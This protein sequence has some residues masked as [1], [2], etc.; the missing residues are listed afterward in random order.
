MRKRGVLSIPAK[1][2]GRHNLTGGDAVVL[3]ERVKGT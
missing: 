3:E 1:L 2:R